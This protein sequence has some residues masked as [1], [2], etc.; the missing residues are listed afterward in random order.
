MRARPRASPMPPRNWS[1]IFEAM[2]RALY[3]KQDEWS[4][5]GNIDASDGDF[6]S[7]GAVEEIHAGL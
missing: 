5:K 2:E 1:A 6:I 3:D 7:P 4:T